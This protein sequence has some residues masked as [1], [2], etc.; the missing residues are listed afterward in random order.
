MDDVKKHNSMGSGIWVVYK[1]GVYDVTEFVAQHPGQEKI[2]LAAGGSIEPFWAMYQ[3]HATGFVAK[4]LE[5]LRIGNIE[6][7]RLVLSLSA[8]AC[9]VYGIMMVK[10]K[11]TSAPIVVCSCSVMLHTM[12]PRIRMIHTLATQS[13][14]LRSSFARPNPS[15][16]KSLQRSLLSSA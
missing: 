10:S 2:L 15:M 6:V 16:P 11:C 7:R 9:C 14:T 3:Q 12:V 5:G 8:L 4:I 13:D 1:N